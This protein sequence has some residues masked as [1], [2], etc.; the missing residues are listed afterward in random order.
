MKLPSFSVY[1]V[2]AGKMGGE[3]DGERENPAEKIRKQKI[4]S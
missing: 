2:G 3:E 1:P 4:E